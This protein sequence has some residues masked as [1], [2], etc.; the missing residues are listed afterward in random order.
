MRDPPGGRRTRM[1]ITLLRKFC[2]E[3]LELPAPMESTA[4]TDLIVKLQDYLDQS[5][6]I[7]SIDVQV[8]VVFRCRKARPDQAPAITSA[9]HITCL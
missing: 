9:P 3:A 6:Q 7:H 5:T 1:Y 4:K 8:V 2:G